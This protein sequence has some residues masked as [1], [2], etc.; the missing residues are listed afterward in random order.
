MV[1][2]PCMQTRGSV[3]SLR[4]VGSPRQAGSSHPMATCGRMTPQVRV[5]LDGEVLPRS[6]FGMRICTR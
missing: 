2:V 4:P 1:D 6:R 5:D 3:G